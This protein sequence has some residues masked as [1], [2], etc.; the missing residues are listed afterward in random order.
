MLT[1]IA[2]LLLTLGLVW[3]VFFRRRPGPGTGGTARPRLPH[4]LHLAKCAGCGTY[5]LPGAPCRCGD[6]G[7]Q[8]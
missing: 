4:P 6:R 7:A 1:K 2:V 8:N 5:R 3:L